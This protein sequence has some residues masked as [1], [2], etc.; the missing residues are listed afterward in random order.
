MLYSTN[1][2]II[3]IRNHCCLSPLVPRHTKSYLPFIWRP[4]IAVVALWYLHS[5]T[6]LRQ[7]V[8]K[9]KTLIDILFLSALVYRT[10][11]CVDIRTV[12]IWV[13]SSTWTTR[14]D[15]QQA[16]V[17]LDALHG[18]VTESRCTQF[19]TVLN[20]WIRVLF[21]I[22]LFFLTWNFLLLGHVQIGNSHSTNHDQVAGNRLEYHILAWMWFSKLPGLSSTSSVILYNKIWLVL[23]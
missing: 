15:P 14:E 6:P 7:I 8:W 20:N 9:K 21:E 23:Q 19:L 4:T 2:V 11:S 13:Q 17:P 16:G 1:K 12:T 22:Q 5:F 10:S 18:Q 3:I